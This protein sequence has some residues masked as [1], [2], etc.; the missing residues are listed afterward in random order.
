MTTATAPA[1]DMDRERRASELDDMAT[2]LRRSLTETPP[3][4]RLLLEDRYDGLVDD[5]DDTWTELG[6]QLHKAIEDLVI[7]TARRDIDQLTADDDAGGHIVGA[8]MAAVR[9][10]ILNEIASR[11]I[12]R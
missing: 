7:H 9:E 2:I 5:P 1:I 11:G 10:T 4:P 6:E 12:A 3:V 8:A